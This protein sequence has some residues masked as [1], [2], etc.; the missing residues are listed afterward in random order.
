M[1]FSTPTP[2]RVYMKILNE[3]A[4][5]PEGAHYGQMV[6]PKLF[7]RKG[8]GQN[9]DTFKALLSAGFLEFSHKG[10]RGKMYYVVTDKGRN[11]LKFSSQFKDFIDFVEIAKGKTLPEFMLEAVFKAKAKLISDAF[12]AELTKLLAGAF[13]PAVRHY[14]HALVSHN[15]LDDTEDSVRHVAN[16]V[17]NKVPWIREFITMKAA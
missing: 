11:L 4:K 5:Y 15:V 9:I 12:K 2:E 10:S 8:P 1:T 16:L 17:R 6:V 7:P 13:N 14:R 3:F